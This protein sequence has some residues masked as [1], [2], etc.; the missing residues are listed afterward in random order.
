MGTIVSVVGREILDSRGNPTVEAELELDSGIVATAAVPS[1]AST[2]SFEAVELRDG[3]PQR[4]LGKGVLKAIE[5]IN[6]N[7]ADAIIGLDSSDQIAID[8]EMIVLDDTPNKGNLGANAIL[9]VSLAAAKVSAMEKEMPFYRYVGGVSAC[10][11]PLP[12]MNILNGGAHADNKLDVQEFM[13]LP[14]GAGSFAE[15]L[16]MGAEVYHFLRKELQNAGLATNVGDEG[17]FAPNLRTSREALEYIV[18]AIDKAKYVPGKD[19]MIGLDVAATELYENGKYHLKGEGLTLTSQEM[20]DY[21]ATLV[22]E[23]PIISIEDGMSEEDWG[24]WKT[25]TDS[26]GK[27]IQLVGDDVFVTNPERI[28]RGI[29]EKVSNAVLIKLNQIGTLMETLRAVDMTHRAG[30]KSVIS[31]RSGETE[32]T[33]IADIAVALNSGQIKTG[34]PARS[35]RV[36]KYNRLLRIEEELGSQAQ[37]LGG[38]IFDVY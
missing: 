21:Y 4:Y 6:E 14:V 27:K 11:L 29:A 15:A 12:M 37:F 8:E 36:A 22:S 10:I 13:I 34:A 32:D 33:S 3:D 35:D 7:I 9:A 30:M 24:G 19:I 38:A 23:Y 1:G 17:G 28:A 2:G 31:H 25:L 16:Q 20:V 26:L 5:N 18:K